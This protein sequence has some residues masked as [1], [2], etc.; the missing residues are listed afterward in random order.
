[1][2][3]YREQVVA[4]LRGDTTTPTPPA[5]GDAYQRRIRPM[6]K[7]RRTGAEMPEYYSSSLGTQ[8]ADGAWHL[9][10]AFAG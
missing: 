3:G 5:T 6:P 7:R 9:G 8:A 10:T 2:S 1:M 4:G